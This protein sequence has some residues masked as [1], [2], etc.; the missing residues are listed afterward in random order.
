MVVVTGL[1]LTR[2]PYYVGRYKMV[3]HMKSY[4]SGDSYDN[5]MQ[6]RYWWK[7]DGLSNLADIGY[8]V[9]SVNLTSLYT[10]ITVDVGPP[11]PPI[12]KDIPTESTLWFLWYFAP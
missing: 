8:K 2:P 6:W 4:R 1:Q 12:S 11:P 10:N 5:F 9:L 3:R 7:K